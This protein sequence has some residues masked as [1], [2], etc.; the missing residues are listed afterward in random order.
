MRCTCANLGWKGATV[1]TG[2]H[3]LEGQMEEVSG[4]SRK[5][6]TARGKVISSVNQLIM[7]G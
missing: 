2:G 6:N 4:W 3:G 1:A 5:A 7:Y